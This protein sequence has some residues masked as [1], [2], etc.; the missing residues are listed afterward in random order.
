MMLGL[1]ELCFT[2]TTASMMLRLGCILGVKARF[3]F[4][5]SPFHPKTKLRDLGFKVTL[6]PVSL[7]CPFEAEHLTIC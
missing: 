4:R 5:C 7:L 6:D 2:T 3:R 1:P